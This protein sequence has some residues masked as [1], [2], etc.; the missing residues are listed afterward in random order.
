ME[1]LDVWTS[2]K[3]FFLRASHIGTTSLSLNHKGPFCI[4]VETSN[5]WVTF[6]HP[7]LDMTHTF[8]ILLSSY[9]L[10][11]QGRREDD[12]EQ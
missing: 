10:I 7:S 3:I 12:V 8:I 2:S 6:L 4:L 11:P 9:D 1:Y 5:I